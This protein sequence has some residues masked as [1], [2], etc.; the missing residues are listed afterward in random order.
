M[1]AEKILIVDD[2]PDVARTMQLFL[3]HEGLPA[4]IALG[5]KEALKRLDACDLVL[6][7]MMMPNMSGKQ[8]LEDMRDRHIRKQVILVSASGLTEA[9]KRELAAIY[10]GI[11]FVSKAHIAEQLIPAVKKALGK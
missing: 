5:G 8:V 7:D 1:A 9:L 10:P 4:G 2:E 11:G 6:L 3:K